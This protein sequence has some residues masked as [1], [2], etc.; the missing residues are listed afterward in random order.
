MTAALLRERISPI[1]DTF[2]DELL[3]RSIPTRTEART[4]SLL[5]AR[6]EDRIRGGRVHVVSV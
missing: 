6:Q 1:R 3:L 4:H 5:R 2:G